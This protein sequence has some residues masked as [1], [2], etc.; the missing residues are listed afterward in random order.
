MKNRRADEPLNIAASITITS[1]MLTIGTNAPAS[2]ASP[3]KNSTSVVT[4][5]VK[6]GAGTPIV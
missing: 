1:G 3:P 4:H 6:N 5:A 2:I